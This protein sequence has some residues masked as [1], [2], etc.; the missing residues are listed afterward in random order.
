MARSGGPYRIGQRFGPYRL[1]AYLGS[2]GFKSVYMARCAEG[3]S[4][5]SAVALGFPHRQDPEGVAEL[6]KEMQINSRL[7]HPNIL[8]VLGMERHEGVA[9]LVMEYVEGDSLREY[10]EKHGPLESPEALR[11]VG[12]IADALAYAHAAHVLHRDIKPENVLIT[13]DKNPRVFDF[14]VARVLAYTAQQASTRIGTVAYMAPEQFQ[15]AAGTNAD[16]WSL[17]VVFY[18]LLTG[19]RPFGG[20]AAEMMSHIINSPLNEAPLHDKRV[21][22]RVVRVVR[23]MLDKDPESRY[24]TAEGLADELELVARRVRL[25]E[26]D[27]GRLEVIIRASFPLVYIVS[28]EEDRVVG[29]IRTIAA[30]LAEES[31]RPRRV[32][33]WSASRGLRDEADKLISP[34]TLQ[35]PT[36]ALNHVVDGQDDAVYV[37]L[38]IHRHYTP[39]TTRLI[40]DAARAVRMTRKSIVFLSP[41]Y[42]APDELEKEITLAFFELPDRKQLAP[43]LDEVIESVQQSGLPVELD[44]ADRAALLRAASGLTRNEAERAFRQ[45]AVRGTGLTRA[46]AVVVA[47]SKSQMIR[48]AGVLEYYEKSETLDDVG[49]LQK[50]LEWFATRAPAFSNTARYAGLPTPKGALLVGVPGCGKSLSARALA[51]S[52]GAPLLR[53]DVGRLFGSVVGASEANLRMAIRTA[54][55]VSPCILWVDELEKGFAGAR[56]RMG[57]RVA[58]R[59]LGSFLNWL[60]DKHSPVFVMATAN[61]IS[62]LPP[63]LLRKGRFDEVFFVGLPRDEEREA[64]LRIH[65]RKRRR[66]PAN[67]GLPGLV[68]A[69]EGFSG[70]EIEEAINDGMFRAFGEQREVTTDD[71]EAAT[72]DARPLSRSRPEE[73]GRLL[74]WAQQNARAAS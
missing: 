43:L 69:T 42:E 14:G 63:E 57:G 24:R 21:D 72:R 13:P 45:A 60:Q 48:K 10:L 53:L 17:G 19:E 56:G 71:I 9:F 27:E 20:D 73:I 46:A 6:S 22:G 66:D 35:D 61:D 29:A 51:G 11:L 54:E 28:F 67:F 62:G 5:G 64:I 36:N 65:L 16:L 25:V 1:E 40:R 23:K 2:G 32:Y 55:A 38:D 74:Q 49:G 41:R 58:A 26:D 39:V 33:V 59:V 4:K 50:L 3:P 12:M 37:F 8:R 52:W 18:E 34:G 47:E 44:D 31:G 70:A 30:R 15:G 7:E 68:Q